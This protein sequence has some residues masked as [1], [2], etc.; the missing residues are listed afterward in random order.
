M[1]LTFRKKITGLGGKHVRRF[2]EETLRLLGK[3]GA[4]LSL[5][6]TGDR[7]IKRFNQKYLKHNW[8]T[9]VLAFGDA[10]RSRP[11]ARFGPH[12]KLFLGDVMI[13]IDR[14][15]AQ[16]KQYGTQWRDELELYIVHGILHIL[17]LDDH[18]EKDRS[19]M[20]KKESQILNHLHNENIHL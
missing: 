1:Y 18:N 11:L 17:G 15:K 7:E 13:S 8:P 2:T 19:R 4:D 9:D 5:V 20:R 12:T 16:A 14:A 3:S 10:E 6:L